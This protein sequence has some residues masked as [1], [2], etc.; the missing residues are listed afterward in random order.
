MGFGERAEIVAKQALLFEEFVAR[1]AKAGR[2][3]LKLKPA[4]QADPAARPLPPEGVR[5]RERRSSMC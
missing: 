5:R 4:G 2:F 3:A 1:E